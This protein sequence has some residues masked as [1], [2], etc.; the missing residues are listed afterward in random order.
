[1]EGLAEGTMLARGF[2]FPLPAYELE[3]VRHDQWTQLSKVIIL[4]SPPMALKPDI[5]ETEIKFST[6]IPVTHKRTTLRDLQDL[7]Q[8][9][10]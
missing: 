5:I 3:T 1:M 9:K 4:N 8:Y 6:I 2:L 7:N 10:N